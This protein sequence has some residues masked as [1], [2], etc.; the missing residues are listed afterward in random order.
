[1]TIQCFV[2]AEKNFITDPML[3]GKPVQFSQN[4]ANMV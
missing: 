1:M 3:H 4:M 2:G